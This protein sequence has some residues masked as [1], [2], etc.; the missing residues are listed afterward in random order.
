MRLFNAIFSLISCC[1]ADVIGNGCRAV[2]WGC[3]LN[4]FTQTLIGVDRKR[5]FA[6][7]VNRGWETDPW[8]NISSMPSI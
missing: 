2:V 8:A 6:V 3:M 4:I 1:E 7:I 5:P